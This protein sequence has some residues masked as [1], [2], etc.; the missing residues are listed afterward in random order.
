VSA[1]APV[2]IEVKWIIDV[3]HGHV[4]V[5]RVCVATINSGVPVG[6][7]MAWLSRRRRGCPLEVTRVAAVVHCAV[8]HGP[9][10]ALGGGMAHPATTQLS[11]MVS[12]G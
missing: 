7:Q 6:T 11:A 8:T 10:P 1:G 9:L 2:L 3:S 5:T 4:P 12:V